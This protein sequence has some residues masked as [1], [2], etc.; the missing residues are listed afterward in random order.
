MKAILT[1]DL[2]VLKRDL[3]AGT[4]ILS[5]AA[6]CFAVL[7]CNNEDSSSLQEVPDVSEV[8]TDPDALCAVIPNTIAIGNVDVSEIPLTRSA[9]SEPERKVEYSANLGY[10]YSVEGVLEAVP[11]TPQT[12]TE[13]SLDTDVLYRMVVFDSSNAIV[14][15]VV[16]K[17]GSATPVSGDAII[18]KAGDYRLFCYSFNSTSNIKDL[19]A[20][21]Q[22]VIVNNGEDFMTYTNANFQVLSS[23]IPTGKSVD[24]KFVRQ[25]ARL[26]L[27]VKATYYSNN[28]IT[29]ARAT[30]TNV[31]GN[32]RWNGVSNDDASIL[33]TVTGNMSLM[34]ASGNAASVNCGKNAS[35]PYTCVTPF[36]GKTIGVSG[37]T[38]DIS[39]NGTKT[40]GTFNFPGSVTFVKGGNYRLTINLAGYY[41]LTPTSPVTIGGVKWARTNLQQ[42][43]SGDSAPVSF[44]ANPWDYGSRWSWGIRDATKYG[45]SISL[46][47]DG[48]TWTA[49][50]GANADPCRSLG[51]SWRLPTRE[52]IASLTDNIA[53]SGSNVKIDRNI[54]T[55][56]N[57]GYIKDENNC[58]AVFISNGQVLALP[59]A[60]YRYTNGNLMYQKSSG[61]YWTS[62]GVPTTRSVLLLFGQYSNEQTQDYRDYSYTLRCVQN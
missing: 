51:S 28:T 17:V 26:T 47:G 46:A 35:T 21:R 32:T 42:S 9:T 39:G 30:L 49:T 45:V 13:A 25:C 3:L 44:V 52:N 37:M 14:G 41:V 55:I 20:D 10:N 43:G 38:V 31:F 11:Q 16:Y 8:P 40:I 7:S 53:A 24:I 2:L 4:R 6:I 61:G 34:K 58:C 48:Q 50:S 22:N 33:A 57:H 54:Y 60:G 56:A 23:D 12:R 29:G 5:M 59:A 15:N 1:R 19:E 62:T 18:L 36:S 27:T